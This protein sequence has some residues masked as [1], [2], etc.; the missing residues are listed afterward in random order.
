MST[1]YLTINKKLVMSDGKL[2]QV[3]T[4]DGT[5]PNLQ[6]KSITYTDNGLK[7]ITADSGYDGLKRVNV[8]VNVPTGSEVS[9]PYVATSVSE[10]ATYLNSTYDG[11][12][13]NY[14]GTDETVY[15]RNYYYKVKAVSSSEWAFDELLTPVGSTTKTANGTYNVK[16][17]AEVIINVPTGITPTGKKEITDMNEV[18]VTNFATAQVVDSNLTAENIKKD[19]TILGITGTHE[20]GVNNP[21]I[22]TTDTEMNTYL[23]DEKYTNMYVKFTG[24]SST[25]VTGET[26]QIVGSSIDMTKYVPEDEIINALEGEY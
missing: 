5:T 11:A 14:T 16:E 19:V 6:T 3:I 4:S 13:I 7:V 26:Y 10:M 15:K 8:T 17:Y 25:Y 20:G 2:V 21:L 12:I 9:N 23:S 24:T 18:D 1:K 22:A